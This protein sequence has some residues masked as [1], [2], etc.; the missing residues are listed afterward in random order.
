ML[1]K[2]SIKFFVDWFIHCSYNKNMYIL[3]FPSILLRY[4]FFSDNWLIKKFNSKNFKNKVTQKWFD[5]DN[6]NRINMEIS[7]KL[8]HDYILKRTYMWWQSENRLQV[9]IVIQVMNALLITS[10][11][12]RHDKK[13]H[14]CCDLRSKKLHLYNYRAFASFFNKV[15]YRNLFKKHFKFAMYK[16]HF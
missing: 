5:D 11:F 16:K 6:K 1:N 14:K 7:H 9:L 13:R 2:C 4:F 10:T 12:Y 8:F 15:I 3:C